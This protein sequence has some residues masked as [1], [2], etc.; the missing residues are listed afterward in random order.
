MM[1]IRPHAAQPRATAPPLARSLP[2]SFGGNEDRRPVRLRARPPISLAMPSF[3]AMLVATLAAWLVDSGVRL[4]AGPFT[5]LL[6]SFVAG[7]VGFYFARSALAEFR[8]GTD[9]SFSTGC[10][11]RA[12]RECSRALRSRLPRPMNSRGSIARRPAY[13][14]L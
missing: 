12:L 10:A 14:L 3:L 9:L 2:T 6:L 13:D 11:A 5:S 8:A 4:V 1:P 7:T